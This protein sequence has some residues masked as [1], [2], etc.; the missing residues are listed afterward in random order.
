MET[1]I[2]S[3]F[4]LCHDISELQSKYSPEIIDEMYNY[5]SNHNFDD[6]FKYGLDNGIY[7]ICLYLIVKCNYIFDLK[8]LIINSHIISENDELNSFSLY[9]R[10]LIYL[11]DGPNILIPELM[12]NNNKKQRVSLKLLKLQKYCKLINSK[13]KKFLYQFNPKYI[14]KFY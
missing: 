9:S 3:D 7:E 2:I 11:I 13:N 4:I 8:E 6:L 5:A 10:P 14:S 12:G 1:T